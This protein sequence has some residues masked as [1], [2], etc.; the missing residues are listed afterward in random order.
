MSESKEEPDG[1]EQRWDIVV[2]VS[3]HSYVLVS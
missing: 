1:I 2:L 3:F